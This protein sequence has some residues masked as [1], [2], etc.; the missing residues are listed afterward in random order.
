MANLTDAAENNLIKAED[1]ATARNIE[2]V[3]SFS[4]SVKKLMELLGVQNL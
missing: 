2:F 3:T 4:G 1:L